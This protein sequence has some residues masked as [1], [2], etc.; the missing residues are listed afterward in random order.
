M[1]TLEQIGAALKAA[2]AAG[3]TDGARRLAAAYR[4][5]QGSAQA[6]PAAPGSPEDDARR[7]AQGGRTLADQ[8]AY[9]DQQAAPYEAEVNRINQQEAVG[10]ALGIGGRAM[11]EGVASIPDIVATPLAAGLNKVLPDSMQ[12]T[13]FRGG[14]GYLLDKAGVPR[15]E[16]PQERISAGVT[17]GLTGAVVPIGIGNQ[18]VQSSQPVV[19]GDG[20]D[21]RAAPARLLARWRG[22]LELRRGCSWQLNLSA[23]HYPAAR[24]AV[25][26]KPRRT[27]S[28]RLWLLR[29]LS[30][31]SRFA[32]VALTRTG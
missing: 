19:R 9:V 26:R 32:P 4:A 11:L 5:M 30:E 15:A 14:V 20:E 2:D 25:A 16:T 29:R 12:Q 24:L 18:M 6:A 10:R 27:Q 28:Y 8:Q 22:S 17:S 1:A 13:D 23:A 21:L 3:D 31:A 7:V